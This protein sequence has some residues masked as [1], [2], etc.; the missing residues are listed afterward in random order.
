M[1]SPALHQRPGGHGS[2]R[3]ALLRP[4]RLPTVPAAH[5]VGAELPS[6]H[7]EELVQLLHASAPTSPWYW[8]AGHSAHRSMPGRGAYEPGVHSPGRQVAGTKA[9]RRA[10]ETRIQRV[11]DHRGKRG[12]QE[13]AGLALRRN[14][15]HAALVA[16]VAVAANDARRRSRRVLVLALLAR[17]AQLVALAHCV[18]A[19]A[20][21]GGLIGAGEAEVAGRARVALVLRAKAG[22][23]AEAAGIARHRSRRA[24]FA[25]CADCAL[26]AGR[27]AFS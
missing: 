5:G 3:S 7:H 26:V 2:H 25:E 24:L 12:V 17:G 4:S 15:R 10:F 6:L 13:S 23:V 19:L 16:D 22:H 1:D 8:P 9:A 11:V 21:F 14:L 20:A 18:R 27:L